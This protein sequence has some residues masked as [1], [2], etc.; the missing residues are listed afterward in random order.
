MPSTGVNLL[1][2]RTGRRLCRLNLPGSPTIWHAKFSPDGERIVLNS[3][4]QHATYVWDLSQLHFEL[5][6]IGLAW[7]QIGIEPAVETEPRK[8]SDGPLQMQTLYSLPLSH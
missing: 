4:E 5:S 6:A 7:K 8:P 2:A 3:N 1:E